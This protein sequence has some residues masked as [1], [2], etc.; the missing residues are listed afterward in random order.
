MISKHLIRSAALAAIV[1]GMTAPG[2]HATEILD[3]SGD[4]PAWADT[5]RKPA[6]TSKKTYHVVQ[7]IDQRNLDTGKRTAALQ[8][9]AEIRNSI[10][11]KIKTEA[12][13]AGTESE[14]LSDDGEETTENYKRERTSKHLEVAIGKAIHLPGIT[15]EGVYWEKL[16]VTTAGGKKV[17]GYKVWVLT[18]IPTKVLHKA[19]NDAARAALGEIEDPTAKSSLQEF[20]KENMSAGDEE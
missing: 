1:L 19:Q 7:L 9:A 11:M 16:M 8:A 18:S 17:P 6:A 15:T 3:R 2:A 5:S 12:G 13:F 20:L 4:K 10:I 14:S